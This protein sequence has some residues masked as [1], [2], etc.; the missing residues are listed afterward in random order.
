MTQTLL[1]EGGRN[2]EVNI[3][4][5]AYSGL[6]L[7]FS[8]LGKLAPGAGTPGDLYLN[9]RVASHPVFQRLDDDLKLT[10]PIDLHT[11]LLGGQVEVA[12]LDRTVM[13]TIPPGTT[14]GRVIRLHGLGMPHLGHP[15]LRGDLYARIEV[16]L[17]QDLSPEEKELLQKWRELRK[18]TG[19]AR[20]RK[21]RQAEP[22]NPPHIHKG[23]N[24]IGKP[25]AGTP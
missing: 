8:G 12:T 16:Q 13:L 10:L 24:N 14:T 6:R 3:P 19:Q 21:R 7:R 1:Q 9:I 11:A 20:D 5:G 22:E 25:G 18:R 4:P 15:D 2:I 17:P 23:Q